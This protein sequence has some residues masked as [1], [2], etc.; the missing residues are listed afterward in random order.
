MVT[1]EMVTE[2]LPCGPDPEKHLATIRQY[3][4]AG[5]DEVY[6]QQIGSEQE[7][8]FGVYEKEVLPTFR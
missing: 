8:F 6:V 7:G 5:F 4:E 1:E 3:I 2:A